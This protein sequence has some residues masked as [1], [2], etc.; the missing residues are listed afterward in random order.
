M[1]LGPIQL[2][3]PDAP[4]CE[5][6]TTLV[7]RQPRPRWKDIFFSASTVAWVTLPRMAE[8]PDFDNRGPKL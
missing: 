6:E 4:R 8:R 7:S 5:M 3:V 1:I 2:R